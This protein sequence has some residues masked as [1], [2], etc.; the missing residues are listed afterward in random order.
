MRTLL[1]RFSFHVLVSLKKLLLAKDGNPT[2]TH[3]L[4]GCAALGSVAFPVP[5]EVTSPGSRREWEDLENVC[6]Q[7]NLPHGNVIVSPVV[8]N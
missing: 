5:V 4:Y 7:N 8:S 3:E 2:A 6:S 1:H